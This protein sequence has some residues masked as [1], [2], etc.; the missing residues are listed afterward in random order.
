DTPGLEGAAR[1]RDAARPARRRVRHRRGSAR[2]LPRGQGPGQAA[3][4][5]DRRRERGRGAARRHRAHRRRADVFR[6]SAGAPRAVAAEDKRVAAA[7][8][9]AEFAHAA[10][11]R[12]R[13]RAARAGEAGE[14]RSTP[15][16]RARRQAARRLR[17]RLG[18]ASHHRETRAD[19]RHA[20]GG[21]GNGARGCV[22]LDA[23]LNFS[24]AQFG[25]TWGP[26]IYTTVTSLVFIVAIII[27]VILSVAYL[28]L[29]ERKL[30][31][32]I[33]VRIG[34]NRVGPYGLLQPFADVLK[35]LF[36]ELILPTNANKALYLAGP[37]LFIMPA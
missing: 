14:R 26:A 18:G 17:A 12:R 4:E 30:I 23:L 9:L 33:Q 36:K 24:N 19:V 13:R 20:H 28:T 8:R 10:A 22:M 2:R 31:G 16:G 3:L 1:A 25:P 21:E 7:A 37:V 5:P 34:P 6:R 11:P 15:H 32:W 27:P 35:L 29:W